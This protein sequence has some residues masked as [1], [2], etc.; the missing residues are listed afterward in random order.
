MD[1]LHD[2]FV[3]RYRDGVP[4]DW[5]VNRFPD[6]QIQFFTEHDERLCI[7]GSGVTVACSLT[8]SE[9]VDFLFQIL[10]T[11]RVVH[12]RVVYLYGARSDKHIAGTRMVCNVPA[13]LFNLLET[14][15][16]NSL[17]WPKNQTTFE[18]ISPHCHK[19]IKDRFAPPNGR[20]LFPIHPDALAGGYDLWVFPDKSAYER[21]SDQVPIGVVAVNC[22]KVRDQT[23]GEI[24]RHEIPGLGDA[25][26]IL[27]V[28]DLC[29]GGRSFIDV[30]AIAKASGSKPELALAIT[31]GVFSSNAVPRLLEH[32][33]DIYVSNSLAGPDNPCVHRFDVWELGTSREVYGK[34]EEK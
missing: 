22:I 15:Y 25:R 28:D 33:Q 20:M 8:D 3:I 24:I 17:H 16:A 5:G 34:A 4:L 19:L 14:T 11:I 27:V 10:S 13:M 31:H 1:K 9:C 30:A 18:F 12:V 32:F 29:D 6:G 21:F 26:R 7:D 2:H 23:T